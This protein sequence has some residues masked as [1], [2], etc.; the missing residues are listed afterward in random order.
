MLST[1]A[2]KAAQSTSTLQSH[3][4]V[5]VLESLEL[6][7]EEVDGVYHYTATHVVY[8][9][10][11][12]LYHGRMKSRSSASLTKFSIED[13][14][15][16]TSIPTAA[17]RPLCPPF[18]TQAP[19]PLPSDN[20]HQIAE[21]VLQECQTCEFLQK[22]P[23]PNIAEY[24]SC[25]SLASE[26][27]D[28][29]ITGI[30]FTKYPQTLMKRVNPEGDGKRAF[31]FDRQTLKNPGKVLQGVENG[32]R[33]LHQLN[34]VHNDINPSNIMLLHD[35]TPVIID[36]DSCR[37]IGESLEGVGRTYEWYDEDVQTSPPSNDLDALRE[38]REWLSDDVTK[39]HQFK[40]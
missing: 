25:E 35:D 6:F 31:T 24:L 15:N 22:H 9:V 34:L 39:E 26:S 8:Q 32:L 10:D 5:D 23:H 3:V 12:N 13:V 20:P 37:Q 7:E 16:I 4:A 33:H 18:F 14:T 30:C 1:R 21:G 40:E 29:E 28:H 19:S 11:N 2:A 17:F 27:R 38:I 36:F